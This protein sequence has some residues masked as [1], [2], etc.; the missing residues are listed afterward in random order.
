MSYYV[1]HFTTILGE[2]TTFGN[3]NLGETTT[4][5]KINLGETTTFGKINLGIRTIFLNFASLNN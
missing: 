1:S 2:T 3:I 4:F 5:G